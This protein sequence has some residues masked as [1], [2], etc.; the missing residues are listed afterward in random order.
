ME[1]GKLYVKIGVDLAA[2]RAGLAE[3]KG[4]LSKFGSEMQSAGSTLSAAVSAPLAA[5]GG[6]AI[7]LAGDMEKASLSFRVLLKDT[8]NALILQKELV[9]FSAQTPFEFKD[10]QLGAKQLLAYGFAVGDVTKYLRTA[11]D[12]AAGMDVK[13]TEVTSALGRLKSGNFGEAFERLRELG[14]DR[15]ALEANGLKFDKSGSYV[16]S[17]KTAMEAVSTVIKDK[18]GGM[19]EAL[20]QSLPGM[21]ATAWDSIQLF[22][23]DIGTSI[24]TS[25]DLK[26]LLGSF[27]SGLDSL[28]EGFSSLSPI[29]QKFI[30]GFGG[31]AIVLPPIMAGLGFLTTTILPAVLAGFAALISPVGLIVVAVAAAAAAIVYHWDSIKA[32]LGNTKVWTSLKD[33]IKSALGV[34]ISIVGVFVNAFQGDW[35]NMWQHAKDIVKYAWNGIISMIQAGVSI[36]TNA[37]TKILGLVAPTNA[38]KLQ[39]FFDKSIGAYDLLKAKVPP[40][41]N[42]LSTLKDGYDKLTSGATI[43]GEKAKDAGSK[44]TQAAKDA[45][46]AL[47]EESNQ[48]LK[49]SLDFIKSLN[50]TGGHGVTSGIMATM[51]A[52]KRDVKGDPVSK[53]LPDFSNAI[54]MTALNAKFTEGAAALKESIKQAGISEALENMNGQISSILQQGAVDIFSGFGEMLG[55]MAMGNQGAG[56]IGM[57]LLSTFGGIVMQLGKMAIGIGVGMLG[58]KAA[59]QSLNPIVAIGAGVALVAMGAMFKTATSSMGGKIGGGGGKIPKFAAGYGGAYKPTLMMFGDHAGASQNNPEYVLRHDQVK[60]MLNRAAD[61]AGGGGGGGYI[62][63]TRLKGSDLVIALRRATNN[64]IS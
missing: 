40:L 30:F 13:I 12:L 50:D 16:G 19:T 24:S 48:R 8:K 25:F 59:L 14:I 41:T 57:M 61:S 46:K 32:S 29:V 44:A 60:S 18:F 3:A 4:S 62:A 51:A 42:A 43:F 55:A 34:I 1:A 64:S 10:V 9:Q 11:G 15:T 2:L 6:F 54:D 53:I 52:P 35:K 63:E 22:L 39:G 45:T 31:L 17:V 38:A 47:I 36:V 27:S 23:A 26:G 56:N 5:A 37:F 20:S 7:K 28:K 58:I 21:L 33:L 49:W